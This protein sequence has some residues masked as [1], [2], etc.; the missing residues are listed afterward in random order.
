VLASVNVSMDVAFC[1]EHG[2]CQTAS[3]KADNQT[4]VGIVGP[5]KREVGLMYLLPVQPDREYHV[6]LCKLPPECCVVRCM[7]IISKG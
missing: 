2:L 5:N 3:G 7:R 6:N 4:M 1:G